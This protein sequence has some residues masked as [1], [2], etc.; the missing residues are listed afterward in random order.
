[1]VDCY[2]QNIYTALLII[3]LHGLQNLEHD[4]IIGQE[5]ELPAACVAYGEDNYSYLS[6]AVIADLE[7]I[8]R[9]ECAAVHITV[10]C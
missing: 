5:R 8:V 4:R 1:M 10:D 9:S 6:H 3:V 7:D 2:S